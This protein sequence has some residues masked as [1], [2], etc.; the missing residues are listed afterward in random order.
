MLFRSASLGGLQWSD[1]EKLM[2]KSLAELDIDV[3]ICLDINTAE[4]VEKEMLDR[5]N[6]IEIFDLEKFVKLNSKQKQNIMKGVPFDRFWQVS[7]TDSIGKQT[8]GAI[9][10]YFYKLVNKT[11]ED[12]RQISFFD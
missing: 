4:G 12:V 1:V 10:K 11:D 6:S 3:V 2:T 9:F 5:I 7:K 8:Y